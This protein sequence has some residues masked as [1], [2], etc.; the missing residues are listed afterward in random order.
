LKRR[1]VRGT[2]VKRS[3][4]VVRSAAASRLVQSL[5]IIQEAGGRR[6]ETVEIRLIIVLAVESHY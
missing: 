4:S 1:D 6:Q 5:M 2:S 3:A